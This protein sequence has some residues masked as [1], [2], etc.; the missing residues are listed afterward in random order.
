MNPHWSFVIAAYAIAGAIVAAMI[1]WVALEH[2]A[3]TKRLADLEARGL[4][5]GGR[6]S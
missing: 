6:A 1:G 3:L 5:R 4:K 2:R